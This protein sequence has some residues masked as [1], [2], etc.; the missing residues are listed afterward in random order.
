MKVDL[1]AYK[2]E[3]AFELNNI[4]AYWMQFT[5]DKTNGGFYGKVDDT[6]HAYPEAPKGVVLNSR[7]L[8]SFSAAFNQTKN[9][10]YLLIAQRAYQYIVDYFIDREYGGVYWSVDY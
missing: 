10:Q 2:K 9:K 6:N 8:W 4:L 5:L 7:I 3:A 1:S